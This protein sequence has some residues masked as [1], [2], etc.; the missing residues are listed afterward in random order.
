MVNIQ[1]C[2]IEVYLLGPPE[3]DIAMI[4]NYCIVNVVETQKYV[5]NGNADEFSEH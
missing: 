4:K 2:I 5:Q 3:T 1:A